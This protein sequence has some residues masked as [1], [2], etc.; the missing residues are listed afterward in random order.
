MPIYEHV[1]YSVGCEE[2]SWW[3]NTQYTV[4]A[5]AEDRLSAY[6]S[7]HRSQWEAGSELPSEDDGRSHG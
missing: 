6:L 3:D 4:E 2:C 5:I 1:T 7:E